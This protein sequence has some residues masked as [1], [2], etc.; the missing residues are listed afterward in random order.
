MSFF[1]LVYK[2]LYKVIAITG[3][4]FLLAGCPSLLPQQGISDDASSPSSVY[5]DKAEQSSG[6]TK[7]DYQI[8]AARALLR[9]GN[10]TAPEQ[11]LNSLQQL[12]DFQ[13][14]E[15]ALLTAEISVA[16]RNYSAAR[17]MLNQLLINTLDKN[18][19]VRYYQ[20]QIAAA[21][22]QDVLTQLRGYVML[23]QLITSP[24]KHQ[25]V[26]D[27]SWSALSSL[28][29]STLNKLVIRDDENTLL[30]WLDLTRI[31]AENRNELSKLQT[32][33]QN[34]QAQYPQNP[35]NKTLPTPLAGVL[36]FSTLN[37]SQV[38]LLLP[39]DGQA[40][41]FGKAIQAGFEAAM[42]NSNTSNVQLNIY[43]TTKQS[44]AE[45]LV[46]LEAAITPIIVG[47]LLKSDVTQLINSKPNL[48]VL[49][50]NKPDTV[51]NLN[52]VCYFAL[53]PED[54]AREA[55]TYIGKNQHKA[56]LVLVPRNEL[57]QR[58]AKA[59]D[60]QWSSQNGTGALVQYVGNV[61]D[62][63]ESMNHRTGIQLA[64]SPITVGSSV[65]SEK[66]DSIY[67]VATQ[68]E[69]T[70]IRAMIDMEVGN[71][72]KPSSIYVSSRSN[73]ATAGPDFR[74]EME[75]IRFSEIPLLAGADNKMY[76]A[77][78][79]EFSGD[80]SQMRLYAFGMDAWKLVN[81]FSEIRQLPNYR[82]NGYTGTLT[83]GN[84]C[85]V[86]RNISWLEYRQGNIVAAN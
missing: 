12:N 28:S 60:E 72:L 48:T 32:A 24:E 58:V 78:M 35:Y 54:E 11:L 81:S 65:S 30:G 43:D 74:L 63:T 76:Q 46:Q 33:V 77:A 27:A 59:F 41:Q 68:S 67:I 75:G 25:E 39:L 50:L 64:G 40:K 62:L 66:V 79:K 19:Q 51:V 18:Q 56:P 49:A 31:Y 16:K 85:V 14:K 69:L 23:G 3:I 83:A 20:I 82:I 10:V 47:P 9:E 7:I 86:N 4:V 53:A 26:I 55:A 29:A 36:Q 21:D 37:I 5:L 8:L 34:W 52:N 17:G 1:N 38:A 71:Q 80:Y 6:A 70:L 42:E 61:N 45:L 84:D 44:V 13:I 15:K 73:N 22:K 57:G 2:R